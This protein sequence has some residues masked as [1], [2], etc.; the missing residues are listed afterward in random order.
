M[1]APGDLGISSLLL[2]AVCISLPVFVLLIRRKWRLAV[3]KNE[4]I[5]K[6]LVLASEEAARVELEATVSYA[7]VPVFSCHVYQCAVCYSPTTTRCA[8]CKAVRYC[9]GK[10]QIIHWRQG[11][12]DECHPPSI[13]RDNRTNFGPVGPKLVDIYHGKFQNAPI[14]T[15]GDSASSSYSLSPEATL[16]REEDTSVNI[17]ADAAGMDSTSESSSTYF[18]GFSSPA[19]SRE[20]SDE[21]SV[22]E[23]ISSDDTEGLDRQTSVD[24]APDVICSGLN[25]VDEPE[26]S[27]PKFAKLADYTDNI[28]FRSNLVEV[29]L[30]SGKATN[31]L[32]SSSSPSIISASSN[33]N[34]VKIA[35]AFWGSTSESIMEDDDANFNSARAVKTNISEGK[36]IIPDDAPNRKALTESITVDSA[37]ISSSKAGNS[38]SYTRIKRDSCDSKDVMAHEIRAASLSSAVLASS[39]GE[40]DASFYRDASE[41]SGSS[42][43]KFKRSNLV[44]SD[45]MIASHSL[46]S[47]QPSG[48]SDCHPSR[49]SGNSLPNA[50]P[51]KVE[52][53][54]GFPVTAN[55]PGNISSSSISG[56]RSSMWK[57]VDQFRGP[58]SGR[59]SN[60]GLFAYDLFV[61]LYSNKVDLQPCGLINCGN[62]CYANAVLQCLSFTPP[63]T[64]YF[65]QGHHSK[66]C[67]IKEWCFTCELENL[68]LKAKD[69]RTP[70][71]PIS[72]LSQLQNIGSNLGNGKE[73]DAHEFLRYAI[74]AMQSIC[75]KEAAIK[76][77]GSI[78]EETTLI[79]L[80]FGGYLKSKIECLKCHY[81]SERLERMMDL[82]VEIEGNVGKLEDALRR[83]T[84]TEILDG[85]NKYQCSRCK[86][87]EKA[88]KKLTI[89]KAPN[90]LTIALKRFQSGKF[91]KL[92]K[93]IRFPEIL[94][95]APYMSGTSDKSPIYR[96][97]AVIVHLDV[98]NASFSGHYVCYVKNGQNR[99]YE[100]DDST[101][102][103]VDL[104]RV[105]TKGA[106]ML[107]YARCSPHAPGLMRN[108]TV[109]PDVKNNGIA[110]R[111]H[112]KGPSSRS[113]TTHSIGGAELQPNQVAQDTAD[114]V[115]SFYL[116][117]HRVRRVLEEDSSSDNFSFTSSNSDEGSCSTN[118]TR[119]ST[120]ADDL[121]D[122]IFGGWNS[123]WKKAADFGTSSSSSPLYSR[124]SP[125]S[126]MDENGTE[127]SSSGRRV[128]EQGDVYD[129]RGGRGADMERGDHSYYHADTGKHNSLRKL[130]IS[131]SSSSC[132]REAELERLG[133]VSSK[134]SSSNDVKFGVPFRRSVSERTD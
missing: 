57:V 124:Q 120:S 32:M 99:W 123:S 130:G 83:F 111:V 96:L 121:S 73:E 63:L 40:G 94:D 30:H 134:S 43:S 114:G 10:C 64:A 60:K 59:Y 91:G 76:A 80:T 9:S 58:K 26:P 66:A 62:S 95:L 133:R 4:E 52:D 100:I 49:M 72:I 31:L 89:L 78:E 19:A 70:I 24:V 85:E 68:V 77:T 79:G 54:R 69:W 16:R 55:Q 109:S 92:N 122:Y 48:T 21:A 23:S 101:V 15:S 112:S 132:C 82:T 27:S 44:S 102:T 119:D 38:E 67:A 106:Y 6:L 113:A 74:E 25:K 129:R 116:K 87:Y 53:V 18:S 103:I 126:N 20:L 56:L 42:S 118:S 61:K 93:S 65:L 13:L 7:S 1:H 75:L 41:V 131:S 39:K 104:E 128:K 81:K 34:P 84:S 51:M 125:L 37:R 88:K 35:S 86:S 115:E 2:A 97:Y 108:G 14:D 45:G 36:K 50:K 46:K 3:A 117:F 98:M 28:N 105:L 11:H 12:K 33:T 127:T 107:L 8:Q 17:I 5:K 71:S 22:S 47:R 110:S 29:K 90:I